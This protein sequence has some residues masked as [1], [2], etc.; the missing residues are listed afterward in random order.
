MSESWEQLYA[1]A[2]LET[3]PR[4]LGGRID[5]AASALRKSMQEP[6]S[7]SAELPEQQWIQDALRTLEFLR[8]ETDLTT[9]EERLASEERRAG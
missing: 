2:L 5:Q 3:D 4:K 7:S 6:G 1:E 9:K 8:K